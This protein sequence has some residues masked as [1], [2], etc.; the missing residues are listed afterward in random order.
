M[1]GM[2]TLLRFARRAYAASKR[3]LFPEKTVS[4]FL[5]VR[6]GPALF[7]LE[8]ALSSCS[9]LFSGRVLLLGYIRSYNRATDVSRS[10]HKA[11]SL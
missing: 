8:T 6:A 7:V 2:L 9:P 5:V 1:R 11:G 10:G 4:F 3:F